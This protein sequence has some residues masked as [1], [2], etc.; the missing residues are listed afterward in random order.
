MWI[1]CGIS[2]SFSSINW[3]MYLLQ[4]LPLCLEQI[5]ISRSLCMVHCTSNVYCKKI[6]EQAPSHT[7]FEK[8][9][10]H[11]KHFNSL[12]LIEFNELLGSFS[13]FFFFFGICERFL[14][15]QLMNHRMQGIVQVEREDWRNCWFILIRFKFQDFNFF[16]LRFRLKNT[17]TNYCTN[18]GVF[19]LTSNKGS[20]QFSSVLFNFLLW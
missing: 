16:V 6:L 12:C 1:F 5:K 8:K 19:C 14:F 17:S 3:Y 9:N 2:S 7:T 11:K 10:T 18:Q 13:L 20:S 4:S 15:Q